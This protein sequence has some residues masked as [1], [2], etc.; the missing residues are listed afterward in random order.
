MGEDPFDWPGMQ[1][2][3]CER[4]RIGSNSRCSLKRGTDPWPR[5][6][7]PTGCDFS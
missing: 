5:V 4:V 1:R 2:P 3:T 6:E 7:N